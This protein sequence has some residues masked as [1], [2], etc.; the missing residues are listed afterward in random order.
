[1][2]WFHDG[3]TDPEE[4]FAVQKCLERLLVKDSIDLVEV[5]TQETTLA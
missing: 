1:M 4:G 3:G 5:K 2:L